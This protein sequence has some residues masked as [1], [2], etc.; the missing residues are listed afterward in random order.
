MHKASD[1]HKDTILIRA[2]A[3]LFVYFNPAREPSWAEER[4]SRY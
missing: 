3:P 4:T 2:S 1:Q